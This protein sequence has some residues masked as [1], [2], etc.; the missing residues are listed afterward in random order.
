MSHDTDELVF[1]GELLTKKDIQQDLDLATQREKLTRLENKII[2]LSDLQKETSLPRKNLKHKKFFYGQ[3]ALAS[4]SLFL[5]LFILF[6]MTGMHFEIEYKS[7]KFS[8]DGAP[9]LKLVTTLVTVL[10]SGG[11]IAGIIMATR[12][13]KEIEEVESDF[14]L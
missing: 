10:G 12:T 13:K 8:Y 9:V 14:Y 11:G 5:S 2:F 3:F 7:T 4:L 1:L 6:L